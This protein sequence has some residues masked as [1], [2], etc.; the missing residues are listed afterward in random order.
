MF[1]VELFILFYLPIF[2]WNKFLIIL[3][4]TFPDFVGK[5]GNNTKSGYLESFFL[6]ENQK[7]MADTYAYS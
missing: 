5:V 3:S 1:P 7:Q 6:L 2:I 4:N